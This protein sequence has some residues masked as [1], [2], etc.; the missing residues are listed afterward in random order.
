MNDLFIFL[1]FAPLATGVHCPFYGAL[2]FFF[3]SS[4]L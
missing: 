3:L 2:P 4:I 1:V